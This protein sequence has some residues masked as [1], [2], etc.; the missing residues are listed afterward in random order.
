MNRRREDF[1]LLREL[2]QEDVD[3]KNAAAER[4]S[5]YHAF[6][7][8]ERTALLRS[9]RRSRHSFGS[10]TNRGRCK[11]L[12]GL[13]QAAGAFV[14]LHRSHFE[15][16]A[17]EARPAPAASRAPFSTSPKKISRLRARL[18]RTRCGCLARALRGEREK[19]VQSDF[20]VNPWSAVA[21]AETQI[22]T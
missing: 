4:A 2:G 5:F 14:H 7:G 9:A 16:S 15:H 13:I 18:P 12:K 10:K 19:I 11:L 1:A 3:L 20:R 22:V 6:S 8:A 21:R 17:S